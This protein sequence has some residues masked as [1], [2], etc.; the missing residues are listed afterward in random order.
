[1]TKRA[2]IHVEN[3]E[4]VLDFTRYLVGAGWTILTA[5]KTEELLRREK[6]P[7]VREPALVERNIFIAD[8]SKLIQYIMSSRYPEDESSGL[9]QSSDT[10]I[11]ILCINLIPSVSLGASEQIYKE[12]V[13]PSNYYISTLLRNSAA[14]FRN[15]LILTDPADYKEA[16]IQLKTDNISEDFRLYLA[17]KAL[18]MIS[19]YDSGIADTLLFSS[20]NKDSFVNY[21]TFP[22]KR[23][24]NLKNG[25]NPHQSACLYTIPVQ[26]GP[27]SALQKLPTRDLNYNIITD[28]SLAWEEICMLFTYLKNQFTVKSKNRDGY[29]FITQFT[30]LKGTVFTIA[31]K[32]KSIIGA[33]LASNVVKSFKNTYT[34]DISNISDVT[35]GCSSVVDEAAAKEIVK[36]NLSAII[37]PGFTP[38][39]KE[40][41]S[42]NKKIRLIPVSLILTSHYDM[43]LFSG[44]LLVQDKDALIFDKW[45][46][47]TKNRPNQYMADQMIFGMMLAMASRTYSAVVLKGNSIVGI[48]QACKSAEKAVTSVL[49]EA[50]DYQTRNGLPLDEPLGELLVCDTEIKLCP[51]VKE[52][53]S[54][55]VSTIIQ[56]GGSEN[57]E[58]FIQY[59]DER[60]VVMV[61]TGMTHITY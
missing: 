59:C 42:A 43:E 37:A 49:T 47:K 54:R 11:Y 40:T 18:N 53:I 55:G 17:A 56:T 13:V 3:T 61:F 12:P 44:G 8:T 24:Q 10:D 20:K 23:Y 36:S 41:L 33:S 14:N 39:A 50:I 35:V 60:N 28:A 52:L 21:M 15:L 58:E 25:A 45:Y 16:I 34:Y 32:Y 31:I 27:M 7:F 22:F 46:V 19:A 38:K 30:P 4:G 48:S 26:S 29:S 51:A 9:N 5:N 1:M 57:D 6:I 2:I